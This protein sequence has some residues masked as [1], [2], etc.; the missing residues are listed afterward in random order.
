MELGTSY[1]KLITGPSIGEIKAIT[2]LPTAKDAAS[3]TLVEKIKN[4]RGRYIALIP[5]SVRGVVDS[6]IDLATSCGGHMALND[7]CTP[8]ASGKIDYDKEFRKKLDN[9]VDGMD[10][11]PTQSSAIYAVTLYVFEASRE[12]LS[13]K[14]RSLQETGHVRS[15]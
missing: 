13:T 9:V 5:T 11:D 2:A 8:L 6:L 3:I 14:I 12:D 1:Q 10:L 7:N 15:H 4:E